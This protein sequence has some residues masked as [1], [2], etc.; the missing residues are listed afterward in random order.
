[1]LDMTFQF[2]P[3]TENNDI[4]FSPWVMKLSDM[5]ST[6][7]KVAE[8]YITTDVRGYDIEA[9]VIYFDA[10]RPGESG[11]I[12]NRPGII[13]EINESDLSKLELAQTQCF[14]DYPKVL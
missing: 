2:E 8:T 4:L 6:Y 7:N 10:K 3:I 1:M 11:L 9:N 12:I 14:I 5:L 13:I